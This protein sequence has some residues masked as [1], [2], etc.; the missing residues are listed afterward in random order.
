MPDVEKIV[1]II[2]AN[3]NR[4]DVSVQQLGGIIGIIRLLIENREVILD[5][6]DAINELIRLLDSFAETSVESGEDS[7]DDESE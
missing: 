7:E 2:R 4:N 6:L 5:L 3:V 1:N